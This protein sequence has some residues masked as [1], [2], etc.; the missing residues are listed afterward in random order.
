MGVTCGVLASS[1]R[2]W[3]VNTN[4]AVGYLLLQVVAAGG[5][6]SVLNNKQKHLL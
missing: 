5:V 2:Y 3:F 6:R 1:S 4:L